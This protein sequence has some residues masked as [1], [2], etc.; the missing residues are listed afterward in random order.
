MT[1][2]LF[3][4]R[5]SVKSYLKHIDIHLDMMYRDLAHEPSANHNISC[6][7]TQASVHG[8]WELSSIPGKAHHE[9]PEAQ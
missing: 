6:L 7:G 9:F 8:I 2:K 3:S 5:R 4:Q 1:I